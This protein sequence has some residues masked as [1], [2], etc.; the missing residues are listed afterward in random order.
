[1]KKHLAELKEA[2]NITNNNIQKMADRGT[3]EQD[4]ADKLKQMWLDSFEKV[5]GEE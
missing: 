5:C 3:I 4:K 2:I 1:M